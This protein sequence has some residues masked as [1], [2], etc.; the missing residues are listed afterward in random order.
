MQPE[1]EP[2][3]LC[4]AHR[5]RSRDPA[6]AWLVL[7]SWKRCLNRHGNGNGKLGQVGDTDIEGAEAEELGTA[8]GMAVQ[9]HVRPS[10]AQRYNLHLAPGQAMEA[11]TQGL[12]DRLLGSK[13]PSQAR[14]PHYPCPAALLDLFFG[15]DTPQKTLAMFLEDLP[16]PAYLD[17]IDTNGDIDAL[18]WMEWCRQTCHSRRSKEPVG[19]SHSWL[20]YQWR[21]QQRQIVFHKVLLR[22]LNLGRGKPYL[23]YTADS[24]PAISSWGIHSRATLVVARLVISRFLRREASVAAGWYYLQEVEPRGQALSPCPY[25]GR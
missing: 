14:R 1:I 13:A 19:H 21:K 17:E 3:E 7:R 24:L 6:R 15:E 22:P 20:T 5:F 23:Y 16:H 2:G 18:G 10:T 25:H 9:G 12:T 4:S 11:S 8:P